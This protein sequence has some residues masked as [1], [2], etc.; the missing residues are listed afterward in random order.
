MQQKTKVHE[1][2]VYESLKNT[3][4]RKQVVRVPLETPT[5]LQTPW[6]LV[7][8]QHLH[9]TNRAFGFLQVLKLF[10]K[11][12]GATKP[13]ILLKFGFRASKNRVH[14]SV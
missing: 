14:V 4:V 10:I 3:N 6:P 9:F 12:S 13:L 2:L 7:T 1:Y 8:L 5:I 11:I